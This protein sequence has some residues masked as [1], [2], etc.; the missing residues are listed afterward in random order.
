[1]PFRRLQP[2]LGEFVLTGPGS[3]PDSER[4]LLVTGIGYSTDRIELWTI[5]KASGSGFLPVTDSNGQI[6]EWTAST[7]ITTSWAN[8]SGKPTIPSLVS[9]LANDSGFVA[10]AGARSAISLT[11]TGTSG[12]A[13]YN[14]STGVLNIPIYGSGASRSFANPSRSLNSSFQISST[15]DCLVSYSV[16]ISTSATLLGGQTGTVF[17][18][19]ADDSGFTTNVVE[20]GRTVNGNTVSLAIAITVTQNVTGTLSGVIPAGKY[21]RIRTDNT[22]GSPS[23]TFRKAQEVLL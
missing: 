1:M 19:Y 23:F 16:D 11:T 22:T 8:I 6:T 7:S 14:S 21:V 3:L 4:T 15:R 18:E 9:Q 17:L 5:E 10:Q 13:T 20:V 2:S 12:A